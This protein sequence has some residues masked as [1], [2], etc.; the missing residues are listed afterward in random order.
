MHLPVPESIRLYAVEVADPFTFGTRMSAEVE[1]A[2]PRIA[3]EIAAEI[4]TTFVD[5]AN[6]PAV[7]GPDSIRSLK[8]VRG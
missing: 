1:A 2:V 4:R 6:W 8:V 5:G 3:V 7:S